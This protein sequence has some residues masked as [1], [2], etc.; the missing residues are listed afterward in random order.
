M[1]PRVTI[2]MYHYVRRVEGTRF[3]LLPA[4]DVAAFEGQLDYIQRHYSPVSVNDIVSLAEG[5]PLPP[6]PILLTFDDGYADH[7]RD[8]FP[9][10]RERKIPAVFF[11]AASSLLDRRVLD[12]NKIQLVLAVGDSA[13]AMVTAIESMVEREAGRADVRAVAEYRAEGW[14]PVRYDNAQVSYVKYML[15]RALPED[16]RRALVDGL[17]QRFVSTDERAFADEF[18]FTESQARDMVA[19]GLTIGCHADKHATLTSLSPE[20]QTKEIDGAL[21]VLDAIG[22][23]RKPFVYSYAKGAYDAHCLELLQARG[24]VMAVTN[25]PAIAELAAGQML[26]LPRIDANHLPTDGRAA[27]NEWTA[28][29]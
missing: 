8:V 18:Y 4:L 7:Y 2:V 26:T 23:P 21:R 28:D 5:G 24:C 29:A 6:R 22:A 11:P 16:I 1:T 27:A 19:D 25:R 20:E 15:Q 13:P 10:L 9:V 14:K 3:P 17:F 12:V